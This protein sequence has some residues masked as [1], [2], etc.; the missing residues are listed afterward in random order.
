[1][2]CHS[3]DCITQLPKLIATY[4]GPGL[5]LLQVRSM[6]FMGW[7]YEDLPIRTSSIEGVAYSMGRD[8][9]NLKDARQETFTDAPAQADLLPVGT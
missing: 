4:R 5:E 1:M 2:Q 8:C 3:V 9:R 7:N 6:W